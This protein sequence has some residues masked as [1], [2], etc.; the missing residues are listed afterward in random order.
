MTHEP[1]SLT[2]AWLWLGRLAYHESHALQCHLRDRLLAGSGDPVP[3]ILLCEHEPV[4]TLGRHADR[5]HVRADHGGEERPPIVATNRGGDVTYHGP[6]QLMVYPV[7]RVRGTITGILST[8]AT[9]LAAVAAR[10]GV[11]DAQWRRDPAGLWLPREQTRW[12]KL[13]A[14]GIHLRRGVI[15]HGFALD[16][17]TPP[18]CWQHIVPCGLRG[19]ELTSLAREREALGLPPPPAMKDIAALAGPML[20]SALASHHRA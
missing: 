2:P 6:G 14:C 4:I 8:I 11:R 1:S 13:A 18:A 5:T 12:A 15:T 19:V 9:T 17:A 20:A 16:V 10:L 7:L 3:H